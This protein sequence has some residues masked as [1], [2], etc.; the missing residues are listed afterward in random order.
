MV[1]TSSPI[2]DQSRRNHPSSQT[3]VS[4]PTQLPWAVQSRTPSQPNIEQSAPV[5]PDSQAQT[6]MSM[7]EPCAEH[8]LRPA[9]DA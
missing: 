3:H 1:G 8:S 7:Q 4:G 5:Q 6:S 9:H 2:S